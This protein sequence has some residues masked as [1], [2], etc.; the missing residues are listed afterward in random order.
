MEMRLAAPDVRVRNSVFAYQ[1]GFDGEARTIL[2]LR[3]LEKIDG[4]GGALVAVGEGINGDTD[5][6]VERERE[7]SGEMR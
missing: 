3:L 7:C 1:E 2:A 6:F 5:G 4:E